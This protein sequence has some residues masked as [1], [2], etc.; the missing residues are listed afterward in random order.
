VTTLPEQHPATTDTTVADQAS[1]IQQSKSGA[2]PMQVA[3]LKAYLAEHWGED[4]DPGRPLGEHPADTAIRLLSGLG[5]TSPAAPQRC[6]EPY[7]NQPSGHTADHG[8]V[9]Y[10]PLT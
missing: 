9:H 2:P 10:Q 3:R 7:C 5:A 8:W 1:P 4:R 6:D